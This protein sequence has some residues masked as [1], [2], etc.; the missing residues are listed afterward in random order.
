MD[1][2]TL[3]DGFNSKNQLDLKLNFKKF[4][5]D[6]QLGPKNAGLITLACAESLNIKKLSDFASAH[7]K[8][9]S[10]TD[11]EISEAKDAASVMGLLNMYYRFRH[12]VG[13]EAYTKPAGLRMNV[14]AR[15]VVGKGP[16]E[17]MALAV[18]ILNGC[19][20]CIKNH[21]ES[22]LKHEITEDQVH[23]L[24]RLASIIKGLEV[25]FRQTA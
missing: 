6:S 5:N 13:K 7:L 15:P 10:A 18:S 1:I 19:E 8:A 23:D 21:E 20:M 11:E 3:F 16:F 2:D 25:A 9:N 14:L 24:A 4:F 12:M 22:V 17:M